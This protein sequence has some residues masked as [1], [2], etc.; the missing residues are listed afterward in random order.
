VSSLADAFPAATIVVNHCGGLLGIGPYDRKRGF[1]DWK[2]LV[3]D[4]AQRPNVQMKLG[5]L[6]ARRCGF[7]FETRTAAATAE[8][9]SSLWRPYIE[10][11][12]ELFGPRRCMFES[13]Y[14]PDRHA[15]AYGTLWNAYK[16]IAAD[17][18]ASEKADLFSETARRVY[19]ID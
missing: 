6:G 17:C 10:T 12:I 13:N 16:L 7:A 15:G 8:E 14:P 2:A 1:A 3:A 18:S 11:C 4:V 5:G 9:L 19:R